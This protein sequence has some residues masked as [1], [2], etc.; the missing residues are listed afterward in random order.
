MI[1]LTLDKQQLTLSRPGATRIVAPHDPAALAQAIAQLARR[2]STTPA[3][4]GS[5]LAKARA[6]YLESR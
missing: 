4:L 3:Q 2:P 1:T 5:R 6:P